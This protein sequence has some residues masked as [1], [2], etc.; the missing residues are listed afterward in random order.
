[1]KK[2]GLLFAMLYIAFAVNAQEI[3]K[4][5]KMP[6]FQLKSSVYE[7]VSSKDLKGKVVLINLF[8][9]WCPPCQVELAEIKTSLWPKYKDNKDFTLL[10]IGREHTDEELTKYNGTKKFTFPLYPDPERKVFD[11]FAENSIP[12]TYLIN[13]EGEVIYNAIGYTKEEFDKLMAA[14]E[15]ALK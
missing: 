3:K 15:E 1:M 12:R 10:V 4:G 2:L 5:D 11:L 14:I 6:D 8:A 9:T 7:N 13:K